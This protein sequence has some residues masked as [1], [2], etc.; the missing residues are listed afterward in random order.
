MK[1]TRRNFLGT[2]GACAALSPLVSA[3][4]ESPALDGSGLSWPAN[5]AL[6]SFAAP[7]HLD[8]AAIQQLSGDQQVLLTTLQGIVNRRQPRLYWFMS[9]DNTDQ[10]WLSTIGVPHTIASD[11]LTLI[12]KYRSEIRGAIVYDPNVPDTIN[13]ATNL[14]GLKNAVVASAD[15]ASQYK[16]QVLEDLR[17]RFSDKFQAYNWLLDNYWPQLTHRL[18]TAISPAS[19]TPAPGVN[20]TTLIEV[21]GHVHDA[22]NKD[23]YTID[24]SSLLAGPNVYVRFQDA[25]QNDGWGP[26]VQQVSVIADGNTIASFQPGT[27]AESPFLYEAD[28]SS[29]ASAW[30]FADNTTYFIYRFT[31]PPGTKSLTMQVLMWNQYLVTATNTTP[32]VYVPFANLRDYI[33]ATNALVFWLDPLVPAEAAL[34]AQILEKVGADTPYLGWFVGGHEDPGVTLCSQHSV[35]VGAADFLNNATVFGGVRAPVL[36]WQPPA[37]IPQLQ[38]KVYVTLTMSEGDNLQYDEHRLRS[39]WDDLNRGQVPINWSISPLLLDA[40][41]SML[42]YYQST[43]TENDFLVAGPS[44]AGYTYPGDW[45]S[46]DLSSF[47]ERTGLYMRRTGMDVVYTLNR[48]NGNNIDFTNAVAQQYVQ[49]VHPLGI[50]GNWISQSTVSTPAGLPV[51]TQVG[52]STVAEG[53]AALASATQNWNGSSPLFVALGVLA[54]NM[55][56]SDVNNLVA[57]LGSQYQV[58][59]ADVFF[60]LFRKSLGIT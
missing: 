19:P 49:D 55:A 26:S 28:S 3:A 9:G 42:H 36:P 35:A 34:F 48:V 37:T 54:W 52:I 11:P 44:G 38:N 53:Q 31:P 21:S 33:V 51:I 29:L 23:T 24:L 41:P 17:G 30:R 47:T 45:P 5:Q 10:T 32:L 43:Q 20:R 25:F 18:L 58:V 1:I 27:S 13:I 2:A 16:L 46:A 12:E 15:L 40:A 7:S 4:Q 14:A 50:L 56:P 57:S 60:K 59:R 39:I 8:A 22:S 6:P